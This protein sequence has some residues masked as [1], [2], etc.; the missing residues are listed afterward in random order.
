MVKMVM[1]ARVTDG[2]VLAASMEDEAADAE[3]GPYKGQ[4]K[5]LFKRLS[6]QSDMRCSIESG[7]N[8][9]HY[10]IEEGVC[11]L[12]LANRIYP[13]KLAFAFLEE[14]QKEFHE[15]FGSQVAVASRPY[16]FIKFGLV[17]LIFPS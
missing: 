7:D 15:N 6:S 9:F 3:L 17:S 5:E 12:C 2:L 1:I 16:A 10:L 13:K 8:T 4:A 11:Y 14:I